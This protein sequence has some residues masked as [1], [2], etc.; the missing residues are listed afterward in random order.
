MFHFSDGD[1][2]SGNDTSEC[3]R[4]IE[5]DMLP[6]VNLFSYGQVESRYGSGQFLRDLTKH[7]NNDNE[8]VT[9][10]QIKDREAIMDSL[11]V[12]LGKGK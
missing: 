4:L 3:L 11:K 10:A 8:K 9:V 6:K 5:N 2:W 1:N 12:F 7:F